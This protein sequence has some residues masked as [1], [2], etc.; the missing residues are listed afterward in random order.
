MSL[1]ERRSDAAL[2]A[3]VRDPGSSF[4]AFYR[5]HV[6]ALLGY[7]AGRG[8]GPHAAAD[9]VS[10]TFFAAL[11]QRARYR[12]Q[13]DTA[14]PWLFAIAARQIADHHRADGRQRALRERIRAGRPQLSADDVAGYDGRDGVAEMLAA[15]PD[16]Q[17]AAV[18]GRVV[19]GSPYVEL[20]AELGV[21]PAAVRQRVSRGLQLL[22]SQRARPGTE[23]RP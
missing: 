16:D 14:R 15:L 22:R 13:H 6:A 10:A 11:Q 3:D 12:P 5:R 8:L 23:E 9:V 18:A 1:H 19:E 7:A 4:T 20:A 2:L 17:R 21:S